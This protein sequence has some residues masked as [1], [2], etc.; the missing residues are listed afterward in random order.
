MQVSFARRAEQ[1]AAVI[2]GVLRCATR[3]RT[4]ATQLYLKCNGVWSVARKTSVSMPK[5]T[6]TYV[7]AII[8]YMASAGTQALQRPRAQLGMLAEDGTGDPSHKS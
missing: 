5:S 2:K 6:V 3:R 1:Q 4:G 7:D 8:A